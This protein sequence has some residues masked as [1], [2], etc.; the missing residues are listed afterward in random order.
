[1]VHLRVVLREADPPPFPDVP[2]AAV[3]SRAPVWRAAHFG[4]RFGTLETPVLRRGVVGP[5]PAAGPFVV[6]DY[7]ATTV[8]PPDFTLRRDT[9]DNLLIEAGA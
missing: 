1:M 9:A 5:D 8:V 7:D 4:D 6:E 2:V 3:S